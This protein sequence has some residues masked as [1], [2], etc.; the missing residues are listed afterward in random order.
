MMSK[1]IL[2]GAMAGLLL[3][4]WQSAPG[5]A[6]EAKNVCLT[7]HTNDKMLKMLYKPP[8]LES[9]EAEG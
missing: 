4:A 9:S 1:K 7:C 2:L 5:F 6:A 8:V 3:L